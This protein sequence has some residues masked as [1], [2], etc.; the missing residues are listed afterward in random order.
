M[1]QALAGGPK[2]HIGGEQKTDQSLA[3]PPSPETPPGSSAS[4]GPARITS[5]WFAANEL[6]PPALVS[7]DQAF[8]SP[9]VFAFSTQLMTQ[10][11]RRT[12][13]E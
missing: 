4:F 8:I 7:T 3:P 13:G 5:K 2:S 12:K 11:I 9:F 6:Q 1:G 10:Y